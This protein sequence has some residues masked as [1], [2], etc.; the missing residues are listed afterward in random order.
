MDL[1][2]LS[3]VR[4]PVALFVGTGFGSRRKMPQEKS[5]KDWLK[6]TNL[7]LVLPTENLKLR[8]ETDQFLQKFQIKSSV[9]F[10]SDLLSVVTR[11]VVDGVGYSFLP[12]PYMA[13]ELNGKLV[14]IISTEKGL[15][16]H[17]LYLYGRQAEQKDKVHLKIKNG[18]EE[19]KK[20]P[21]LFF[22]TKK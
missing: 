3:E 9:V 7:G 1:Y 2:Q 17:Q 10:E 11:A 12:I 5:M 20:S 15:W 19:M 22:S 6:K 13:E 21:R 18:I 8:H 4:M 14:T 16:S